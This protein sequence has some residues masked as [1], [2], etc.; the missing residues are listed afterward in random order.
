MYPSRQIHDTP[1]AKSQV[2][3]ILLSCWVDKASSSPASRS[4]LPSSL[5]PT[6]HHLQKALTLS[7]SIVFNLVR[8]IFQ[9]SQIQLNTEPYSICSFMLKCTGINSADTLSIQLF[10][11]APQSSFQNLDQITNVQIQ[12]Q[13]F[14]KVPQC[15]DIGFLIW[16]LREIRVDMCHLDLD[17]NYRGGKYIWTGVFA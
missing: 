11:H 2:H 4:S 8:T 3:T 10:N 7:N 12:T 6:S 9:N 1:T 5:Y 16:L 17:L 13:D 14:S 15:S